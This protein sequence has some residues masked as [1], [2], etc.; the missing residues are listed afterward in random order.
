[1]PVRPRR[2][3]KENEQEIDTRLGQVKGKVNGYT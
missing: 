2:P 1:M 3:K